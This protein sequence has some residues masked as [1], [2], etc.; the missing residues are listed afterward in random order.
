M[1]LEELEGFLHGVEV[2][3]RQEL[4]LVNSYPELRRPMLDVELSLLKFITTSL[5]TRLK[6]RQKGTHA[7]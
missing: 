5:E 2:V 4:A 3:V 6:E 1:K 7:A